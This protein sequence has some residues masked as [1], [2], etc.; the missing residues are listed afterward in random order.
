MSGRAAS[1][2]SRASS[3]RMIKRYRDSSDKDDNQENNQD[4]ARMRVFLSSLKSGIRTG[5][6]TIGGALGWA[7]LGSRL[8]A[9]CPLSPALRS[10]HRASNPGLRIWVAAGWGIRPLS[11]PR[12]FR[13][14]GRNQ[15]P[16]HRKGSVPFRLSCPN[17][18]L[19]RNW[20]IFRLSKP[21]SYNHPL[22][23]DSVFKRLS[24]G[25]VIL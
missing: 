19:N 7:F 13:S 5:S 14:P 11:D 3:R 16:H 25:I 12:Q 15:K 24:F 17:K 22:V 1:N 4:D 10:R 18:G 23:I 9:S 21:S 2:F 20:G 8:A 6:A